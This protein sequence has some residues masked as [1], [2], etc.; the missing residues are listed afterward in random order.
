MV[1]MSKQEQADRAGYRAIFKDMSNRELD[2]WLSQRLPWYH[3]RM[4][5][6]VERNR[7]ALIRQ[8]KIR[9]KEVY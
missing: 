2:E 6:E 5:A 1:P 4:Q 3:R 7:L 9:E 8:S